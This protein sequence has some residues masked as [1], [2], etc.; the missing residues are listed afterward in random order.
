MELF[1]CVLASE[2]PV[3]P[4]GLK[5]D[6]RLS[7]PSKLLHGIGRLCPRQRSISDMAIFVRRV[8]RHEVENAKFLRERTSDPLGLESCADTARDLVKRR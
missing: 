1:T 2:K 3:G 6:F 5:A 4:P 8:N 7:S